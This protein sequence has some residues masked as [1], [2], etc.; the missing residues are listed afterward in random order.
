MATKQTTKKTTTKK[1]IVENKSV[2][3]KEVEKVVEPIIE[4]ESIEVE[5]P[6]VEKN[7]AKVEL[8]KEE[9]IFAATD[10]VNCVSVTAG[11]LIMIGKKSGNLYRWTDCGDNQEV[12]YQDLKSE[13]LNKMSKYIYSPL[14]VIED[15]D[16]LDSPDFKGVRDVYQNMLTVEDIENI[17]NLD[18]GSFKRTIENLPIGL[19]NTIKSLA[20]TKIQDGSLD[21]VKK[22]QCIDELLG[23]DLFNAYLGE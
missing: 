11:E 6:V 18:I 23:T 16:V 12:E 21:S 2:E 1:D 4:D 17:F 22:I 9:K 19:K 5:E 10:L 15:E 20:V 7:I 3:N 14:F 8:P 13:K